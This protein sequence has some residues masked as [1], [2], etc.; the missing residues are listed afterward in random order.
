MERRSYR[1]ISS[2]HS[3]ETKNK[4]LTMSTY[5]VGKDT[6]SARLTS[7]FDAWI[8]FLAKYVGRQV[9]WPF[10]HTSRWAD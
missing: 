6:D 4:G 2:L 5:L 9:R 7:L 10:M 3:T 1:H 8:P